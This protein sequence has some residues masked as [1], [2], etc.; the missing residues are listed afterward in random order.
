MEPKEGS[1]SERASWH[2]GL[3]LER[4]SQ[5]PAS[6]SEGSHEIKCYTGLSSAVSSPAHTSHWGAHLE[7]TKQRKLFLQLREASCL[8]RAQSRVERGGP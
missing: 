7:I 3:S 6:R 1:C 4:S 2:L 5:P 8:S